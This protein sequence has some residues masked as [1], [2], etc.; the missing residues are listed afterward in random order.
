MVPIV[1]SSLRGNYHLAFQ[2]VHVLAV[3]CSGRERCSFN[4]NSLGIFTRNLPESFKILH[5]AV[6]KWHIFST[7]TKLRHQAPCKDMVTALQQPESSKII[8]KHVEDFEG[9]GM[10]RVNE[11]RVP[12]DDKHH[13]LFETSDMQV[14]VRTR[15]QSSQRYLFLSLERCFLGLGNRTL[16]A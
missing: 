8:E 2:C 11:L 9:F 1:L 5:C 10:V 16:P 7:Y 6:S 15:R 3:Y 4:P 14:L 13:T 12:L